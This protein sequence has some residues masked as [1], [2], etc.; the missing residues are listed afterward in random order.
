M[1]KSCQ[2]ER[3]EAG[4]KQDSGQEGISCSDS[5]VLKIQHRNNFLWLRINV[6]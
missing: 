1:L 5:Q 6:K 3:I 4:Q 2:R